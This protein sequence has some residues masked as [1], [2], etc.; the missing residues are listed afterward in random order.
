[1]NF[2]RATDE[3][4]VQITLEDLAEEMG[5]SV[6]ALRQARAAEGSTAHRSPPVG[7]E[8]AVRRMAHR[9]QLYFKKLADRL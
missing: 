3:L 9:Q 7:W 8:P 5:I 4:L 6:Q 1:V 2:R